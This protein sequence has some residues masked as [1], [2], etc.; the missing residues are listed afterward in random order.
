MVP[1]KI[2][3]GAWEVGN[4]NE[5]CVEEG[6]FEKNGSVVGDIRTS[7]G[8]RALE[9]GRA[10]VD[11]NESS[12]VVETSEEVCLVVD[13]IDA[14]TVLWAS[15]KAEVVDVNRTFVMVGDLFEVSTLAVVIWSLIQ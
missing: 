9:E 3:V 12:E 11:V 7:W 6:T 10:V 2:A 13:F 5:V 4:N 14:A 1:Y 8:V 15:D